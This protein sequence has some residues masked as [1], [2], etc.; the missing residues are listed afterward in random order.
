M[1]IIPLRGPCVKGEH[2]DKEL[3]TGNYFMSLFLRIYSASFFDK[4]TEIE[5]FQSR[6][7]LFKS[8][9]FLH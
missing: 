3:D 1:N 6:Y 4:V 9:G 2:N 5:I 7:M 8:A